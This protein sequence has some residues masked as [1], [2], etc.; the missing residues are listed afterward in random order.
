MAFSAAHVQAFVENM[1]GEF[2]DGDLSNIVS[3]GAKV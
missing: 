3:F 2:D 1:E